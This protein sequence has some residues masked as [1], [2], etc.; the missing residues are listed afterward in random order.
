M[1]PIT[2]DLGFVFLELLLELRDF[3]ILVF[4]YASQVTFALSL[5]HFGPSQFEGCAEFLNI[6]NRVLFAFPGS[7]LSTLP[8]FFMW[9]PACT[10][11]HQFLA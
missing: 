5:L 6:V 11:A 4:G 8:G 3:A 1:D 9:A 10:F 2:A 7:S